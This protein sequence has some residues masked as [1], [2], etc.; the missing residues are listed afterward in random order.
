MIKFITFDFDFAEW[1]V[2]S[3]LSGVQLLN[4]VLNIEE[5]LTMGSTVPYDTIYE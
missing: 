2:S 4:S 5:N 3:E 1:V